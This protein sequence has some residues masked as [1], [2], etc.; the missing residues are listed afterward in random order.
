[1]VRAYQIKIYRC[2][3]MSYYHS[4]DGKNSFNQ[5]SSR[6][7]Q[8]IDPPTVS[9]SLSQNR[10]GKRKEAQNTEYYWI[11]GIGNKLIPILMRHNFIIFFLSFSTCI[12]RLNLNRNHS[13][14]KIFCCCPYFLLF[15]RRKKQLIRLRILFIEGNGNFIIIES[16][17]T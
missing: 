15:L 10:C 8:M 16:L 3:Q 4:L 14:V 2:D 11:I 17:S 13:I 12:V 7:Y 5:K 9:L 1:M 6:P